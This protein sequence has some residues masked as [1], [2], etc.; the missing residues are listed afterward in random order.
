MSPLG[1]PGWVTARQGRV[2]VRQ[3]WGGLSG[4][5]TQMRSLASWTPAPERGRSPRPHILYLPL[6][7][8]QPGQILLPDTPGPFKR[9]VP[10]GPPIK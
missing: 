4:V 1:L 10:R 6:S 7:E 5:G 8:N 9:V 2:N 3:A